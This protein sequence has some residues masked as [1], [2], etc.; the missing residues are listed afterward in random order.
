M[1]RIRNPNEPRDLD[2]LRDLLQI[3]LRSAATSDPDGFA[4]V[5]HLLDE[6]AGDGLREACRH[7]RQPS[8]NGTRGYSWADIAAALDTTRS[9][10][11][12]RFGTAQHEYAKRR[13]S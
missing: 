6:A 3:V 4:K 1:S 5:V 10:V 8:Q 2:A 12:F 13:A 9:A 7:M 11:A